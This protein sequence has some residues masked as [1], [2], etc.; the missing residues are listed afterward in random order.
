MPSSSKTRASGSSSP[1]SSSTP[2]SA[3]PPPAPTPAIE[4][5]P[6]NIPRLELDGSNWAIFA[7]RFRE[8]MQANRR[9]GFFDGTRARPTLTDSSNITADEQEAMDRWDYDDQVARYLLSQRL[10]DSTAVRMGPY[11]TAKARWDRVSTEFTAKSV[12]A[13]NDLES[14]FYEMRCQKGEDVRVFLTN[15]RYK[16]E[17]LAAAGV[18]ITDRD[19]QRTVLR[20]ITEELARFASAILSSAR[21]F[22]STSSVDTET[23]IDHICEEADRLKN[24]RA[25][26]QANQKGSGTKTQATGDEALAATGSEGRKKRRKGKCHNCGKPGH[27]ARECRSPK[28]EEKAN[29]ETSKPATAQRSETKPVGSANAVATTDAEMDGAWATELEVGELGLEEIALI[30][31]SDW[32]YEK[33]ETVAAVDRLFPEKRG[34][35]VELYDS[36]A[37]RHISPYKASFST[38]V[39]LDPPVF[40]NAANQQRFPAIGVGSL[41]IHAPNGGTQSTLTLTNV[42][43]APAVGFTLVS[44]G[45]LDKQ[46]YRASLG[47]G[48]LEL[49]APGG[50]RIARIPQT[51]RGLYRVAHAGE[52]AHVVDTISVM[53]LHRRMGHIAPNAARA[54]VE[55][56]L[57]SGIRL[58]PNS[59][60]APCDACLFARA[61]RKPV[62]KVRVGP[63]SQHFGEEIHTDVWGP[64]SIPSKRGCRYFI[65]FTDDATRYT[66]TYLLHTKAEGLDAYK[67]FEAWA[68]AQQ[69][70]LAIKVLHSDRGG[71]YLSEAFDSH[72]AAAGTARRLTVHDTPQ[73]NGVAER[74]NRTLLERIRAF[75]HTSGLPKYLWGEALRHATWLKNRTAT[76]ALDGKTPHQALLGHAPNLANLQPWGTKVWVHVGDGSKLSARARE[77]RWLGFDTE[78]HAHRV[79]FPS[80]RNVATER[81]I[82]FG[83]APALEGEELIIPSTERDQPAAQP[84]PETSSTSPS[85]V[86]QIASPPVLPPVKT[87]ALWA[88]RSTTPPSP[89]TPQS[90]STSASTENDEE[91]VARMVTPRPK[92]S[93][94]PSRTLRDLM[95]GV[96]VSSTR[97]ADPQFTA[98]TQLPGGFG[99]EGEQAWGVWSVENAFDELED[100]EWLEYILAAEVAEAEALEPRTL[101]E[102]KRRPDWPLWEKAISEEL[103]TLKKAGTWR[104]EEA[105]PGAN[106]IG[107]KWVFKAK[108]DAAGNIARYKARLVAQGF[109]QIGGVDYDDTYAP[110]AKLASSRVVIAM[111][112]RLRLTLHQVDIKGAYLNGVLRDDEV[113][114]MRQPPGYSAPGAGTRVLRLQKALYGLK[115]AGRRW[116]QTFTSILSKLGFSQCS[117]DQ[118]VYHRMTTAPNGIIII[119]V[120]VDD[121]TIAA[122]TPH[123]IDAFKTGLSKHVEVTDLGELHW[124]LG[125]EVKRD[126][127]ASTIHLSQRAYIDAI[128]HR[129][130]LY[131]PQTTLDSDGCTGEAHF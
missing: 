2:A 124:M 59:R 72:L 31:E 35:H 66:V 98:G 126:R 108:K 33:V 48:H 52:E 65:T 47:G 4:H 81:N 83:A 130:K 50:E 114:Y 70:C 26:L 43:H 30:D 54:L 96:G 122:S 37:T 3:P 121:C 7:M 78:S 103:S 61:T 38:Y 76:R 68:L 18:L 1:T 34:E 116:Y 89:L 93:R 21:I 24:R 106:V 104:L 15:L 90:S 107:S 67:R 97:R 129:F 40:L 10:P 41:A 111:A 42:L 99:E 123:L 13:Q 131:R 44:L 73:L 102:A 100:S 91:T 27:W 51:P 77:G 69:H 125:I 120:H 63:Q 45:A 112:N 92:R 86:Q 49:F 127:A 36:G 11:T 19:Y 62:P 32:L 58:D 117:V 74:L 22:G 39:T 16:R 80:S 128:L 17:E 119:A 14:A 113:L 20:G 53:E 71:E 9:W 55:K 23:L 101:A 109:S 12:Y 8:A 87:T 110:V 115:Q 82:F 6:Q 25:K 57:V 28:K 105:P 29:D 85:P 95:E 118:A 5:L 88:P 46:G 56:G 75:T 94:K 64:C 60:E 84:A 79:Y